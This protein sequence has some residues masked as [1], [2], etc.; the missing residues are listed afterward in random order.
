[1]ARQTRGSVTEHRGKD[2][3]V[4]RS[5]RFMVAGKSHRVALGPVSTDEAAA[6]LRHTMADV[7]RGTW[8][9]AAALKP[10]P[11]AVRTFRDF[12]GEWWTLNRGQLAESTRLDYVW[13]LEKHLIPYFGDLP[14]DAITVDAVE[15]YTAHKLAENDA[16][17]EAKAKG[18]P[19]TED[20]TDKRGR[21]LTREVRPLSPRSIN[22]TVTLL[23]AI[24][25]SALE[26]GLIE[27]NAAR[28]KRRR[29]HERAPARSYLE[30][31]EQITAL[32]DA[33][34]ELD[35]EARKGRQ[36]V[37][38]RAIVATLTFGGLRIGELCALR[39]RDVDLAGGWLCVGASKTDA[40][41]RKVGIR[42][43][44]RDELLAA[45]TRHQDAPQTG[46]VFA[47]AT[48]RKPSKDNLRSRV[49]DA[50][51]KRASESLEAS[52]LPPLPEHLTP[53]SL[54]H[55]FA[56]VM[57]ALGEDPGSVMDDMGHTDPA[58]ALRLYRHA[59]RRS[60]SERAKLRALVEGSSVDETERAAS[61]AETGVR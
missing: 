3:Q 8:R 30:S 27:R 19:L 59:M 57:Y 50:T 20:I 33:A 29:V 32:L 38:R 42:G 9:P 28:G 21:E 2:G 43:A 10:L 15:G 49:I 11:E 34:G 17:R 51:V 52:G 60:E 24:L 36:H 55:T 1:M 4:Y 14:L 44:L 56:S 31:A 37:E 35:R 16:I 12:A 46:Y 45:R 26:R 53:H 6:A 41:V 48:G 39:W 54:R 5:L 61:G 25:E 47:T 7:E 23:G 18:E 13:R 40:G 22:M 58:L